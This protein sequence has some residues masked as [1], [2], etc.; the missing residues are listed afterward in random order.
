VALAAILNKSLPVSARS[1]SRAMAGS[2]VIGPGSAMKRRSPASPPG[3]LGVR[4]ASVNSRSIPDLGRPLRTIRIAELRQPGH[5]ADLARTGVASTGLPHKVRR[6]S[7]WTLRWHGDALFPLRK[8]RNVARGAG[9]HASRARRNLKNSTPS[10]RRRF[11]ISQLSS[12]SRTISQIFDGL[13]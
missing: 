7:D 5:S 12:I 10:C 13:K 2:V 9:L 4:S 3:H 11:I 8:A 6:P 1:P